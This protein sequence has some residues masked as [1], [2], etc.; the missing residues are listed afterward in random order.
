M[1]G[2]VSACISLAA[3]FTTG[4]TRGSQ[5]V[6]ILLPREPLT[7]LAWV[8][9]GCRL[10]KRRQE[11]A[12]I[13]TRGPTR[14]HMLAADKA[15]LDQA[16]KMIT[17]LVRLL[18][19]RQA[20]TLP[21]EGVLGEDSEVQVTLPHL[22]K[23]QALAR[24]ATTS[25]QTKGPSLTD[26]T[27]AS[28]DAPH[29]LWPSIL[30]TRVW[31]EAEVDL[32]AAA[33]A[34]G[35]PSG[36]RGPDDE[37][38][39]A[40]A[41]PINKARLHLTIIKSLAQSLRLAQSGIEPKA[42]DAVSSLWSTCEAAL[43]WEDAELEIVFKYAQLFVQ[44]AKIANENT[45]VVASGREF[46][47]RL[48]DALPESTVPVASEQ[49]R[50]HSTQGSAA[51]SATSTPKKPSQSSRHI[52][53]R[54][55]SSLEEL[56][57]IDGPGVTTQAPLRCRASS[58]VQVRTASYAAIADTTAKGHSIAADGSLTSRGMLTRTISHSGL[59]ARALAAE[60]PEMPSDSYAHH[61]GG[62]TITGARLPAAGQRRPPSVVSDSPS[63]LFGA[64]TT[65]DRSQTPIQSEEAEKD[66]FAGPYQRSDE[67]P[68]S[69]TLGRLRTPSFS[70]GPRRR[71]TSLY[72]EASMHTQPVHTIGSTASAYG[73]VGTTGAFDPTA[74]LRETQH[75][76]KRADSTASAATESLAFST[77]AWQDE[78]GLL[79]PEGH[80]FGSVMPSKGAAGT[81]RTQ[82]KSVV[83]AD[84][85]L[86]KRNS[87]YLPEGEADGEDVLAPMLTER[88]ERKLAQSYAAQRPGLAALRGDSGMSVRSRLSNNSIMTGWGSLR[89]TRLGF[90]ASRPKISTPSILRESSNPAGMSAGPTHLRSGSAQLLTTKAAPA[91]LTAQSNAL[92]SLRALSQLGNVSTASKSKSHRKPLK[93]IFQPAD[94]VTPS[95]DTGSPK[96]LGQSLTLVESKSIIDGAGQTLGS[97][98]PVSGIPGVLKS[99]TSSSPGKRSPT[100]S[101][102]SVRFDL[103]D[104]VEETIRKSSVSIS[105]SRRSSMSNGLD[106][107]LAHAEDQSK[108]K[109]ASGCDN[110]GVTCINAP[111]DRKGRRFCSR[112]CRMQVKEK[113]KEAGTDS[114]RASTSSSPSA[115]DNIHVPT[116]NVP[117]LSTPEK[118]G[119]KISTDR[120]AV[121]SPPPNDNATSVKMT[122]GSGSKTHSD[123]GAR[124]A[125]TGSRSGRSHG[126]TNAAVSVSRT[127]SPTPVAAT[128]A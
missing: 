113:E 68:N 36:V 65:Q 51:G 103:P 89:S 55:T 46:W 93:E 21:S 50:S 17:L 105:L 121:Q 33:S 122:H 114:A 26:A 108:L 97:T 6:V 111:V 19:T 15:A 27:T 9:E 11:R 116:R 99:P 49:K 43:S 35:R 92:G 104:N 91:T 58:P 78:K 75:R 62:R 119:S 115:T 32:L 123:D 64:E 52:L 101:V 69:S 44:A 53:K 48:N 102:R 94:T 47:Q 84:G 2:S 16:V 25:L 13:K 90:S 22:R 31:L 20:M 8:L 3:L 87:Q 45:Q 124:S 24:I 72:S 127:S 73:H 56:P 76:R 95:P 126:L 30:E 83:Q 118:D 67:M 82:L 110:C 71:V 66:V 81:L 60:A 1:L 120:R 96:K 86:S 98:L 61:F 12:R 41:S 34:S 59:P 117:A 88:L 74:S 39:A 29:Q 100:A 23:L 77:Q 37:D 63:L 42:L 7:A 107:A 28:R 54:R 4:V 38:D 112:E 80:V 5:P 40:A 10:L 125:A 70:L 14:A 106:A 18:R 85:T 109:T 79:P 128:G 57:P